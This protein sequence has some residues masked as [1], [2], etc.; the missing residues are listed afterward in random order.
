MIVRKVADPVPATL[1]EQR[2]RLL[3]QCAYYEG[4]LADLLSLPA[5]KKPSSA[6]ITRLDK[7]IDDL[8]YQLLQLSSFGE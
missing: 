6:R 8:R 2:Q 5:H 7:R 1:A 4:Q 3:A